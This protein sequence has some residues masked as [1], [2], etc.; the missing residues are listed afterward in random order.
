MFQETKNSR[1]DVLEEKKVAGNRS[2]AGRCSRELTESCVQGVGEGLRDSVTG[3]PGS[4][5][6]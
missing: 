1:Q 3:T 4:V 5:V 6:I 2:R